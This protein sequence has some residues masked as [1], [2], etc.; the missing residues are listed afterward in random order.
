MPQHPVSAA[1]REAFA[2]MIVR[3]PSTQRSEV[4]AERRFAARADWYDAL[5]SFYHW[6]APVLMLLGIAGLVLRLLRRTRRSTVLC[7]LAIALAVGGFFRLLLLAVIDS[8]T[9]STVGS[10]YQLTTRTL[11]IA[12]GLTGATVIVERLSDRR[13]ARQR[14]ADEVSLPG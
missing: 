5:S 9:F 11:L 8:T 12:F 10:A 14:Q 6:L 13:S 7:L 2:A 4:A 3:L 1:D